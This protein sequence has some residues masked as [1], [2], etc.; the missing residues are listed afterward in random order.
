MSLLKML[1]VKQTWSP[2]SLRRLEA[3]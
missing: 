1:S 3:I 2:C